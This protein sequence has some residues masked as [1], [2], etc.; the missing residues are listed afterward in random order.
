M[1][2]MRLGHILILSFSSYP[3]PSRQG[4][5][6]GNLISALSP[7][8]EADILTIRES[9]LGYIE[10]F[11][12]HRLLRVPVGGTYM[13]KVESFQRAISRQ[14]DGDEY[15]IIHFRSPWEGLTLAQNLQVLD[16][17][18]IYEPSLTLPLDSPE[19]LAKSFIKL[20]RMSMEMADL[21]LV[22]SL[23]QVGLL[24]ADPVLAPKVRHIPAGIDVNLFDFEQTAGLS[25]LDVIW[26]DNFND[27]PSTQIVFDG[28]A[29]LKETRPQ[30]TIG[31]VGPI[32]TA[33]ANDMVG[34]IARQGLSENV[35][36]FGVQEEE[37]LP[38]LISRGR[39]ALVGPR[40][41]GQGAL[42]REDCLN[43]L[44]YMACR[45]AVVA[46]RL[47]YV[48]EVTS[49][50]ELARLYQ[51]DNAIDLSKALMYQLNNPEK[52]RDMA[53]L[54]Y[55]TVREEYTAAQSRRRI[56]D[57]YADMLAPLLSEDSVVSGARG[58]R[59][60]DSTITWQGQRTSSTGV[61]SPVPVNSP[62]EDGFH[63]G[64]MDTA[65][66][67]FEDLKFE[68]SGVLLG[69][70]IEDEPTNPTHPSN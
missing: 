16:A 30:L 45:T 63:A 10:K 11:R 53:E 60:R 15:D 67:N 24:C 3:S 4:R 68:A 32:T 65:S 31:L 40:G 13:Q 44:E 17:K 25:E 5:L 19:E 2:F 33:F 43:L 54:A 52:A 70:S 12:K 64:D 7:R 47:P 22:P 37:D 56:V 49:E 26:V 46:P 42:P 27:M 51:P 9:E 14:L 55:E 23:H 20:D 58:G 62:I 6:L 61:G 8:F 1:N 36:F 66:L 48:T 34:L 41:P 21:I 57:V 39:V 50:G 29:R 28:L 69:T 38:L 18:F 59:K 35:K